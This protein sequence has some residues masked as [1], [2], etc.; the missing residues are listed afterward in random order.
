MAPAAAV[1]V[2]MKGASATAN[3]PTMVVETEGLIATVNVP[4]MVATTM[5]I[6]F[7]FLVRD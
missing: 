6:D 5:T 2:E 7:D 1:V 4:I 3:A